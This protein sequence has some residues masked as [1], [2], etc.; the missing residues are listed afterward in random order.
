[1]TY[2]SN[3]S[4]DSKV[5]PSTLL[6]SALLSAHFPTSF[7]SN[8]TF[9]RPSWAPSLSD[10]DI[11]DDIPLSDFIFD[12]RFRT[13]KCR[14]SGLPFIDSVS[15]GGYSISETRR[16]IEWLAAG[17][18]N[19]LGIHDISGDVWQRVVGLFAVNNVSQE[20]DKKRN[21]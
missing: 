2:I 21:L 6:C 7:L 9:Y 8:M 5:F 10:A 12:D 1:M 3:S 20:Y 18:A 15:G 14:D 4:E 17:L 11:P 13:R 16:R 19:K